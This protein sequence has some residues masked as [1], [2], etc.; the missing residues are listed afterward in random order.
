MARKNSTAALYKRADSPQ[1]KDERRQMILQAATA[2]LAQLDSLDD[3]TMEALSKRAGLAKGTVYLYFKNKNSLFFVM[4]EDAV[5][6]L[7]LD[8]HARIST[9][10]KPVEAQKVAYAIRDELMR[11]VKVNRLPWLFKSLSG[12]GNALGLPCA[13]EKFESK[14]RPFTDRVDD[15]LVKSLKGLRPENGDQIMIYAWSLLLGLSEVIESDPKHS[16][17]KSKRRVVESVEQGLGD[18]L[19]LIIEGLQNRS[20]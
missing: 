9:L 6:S 17:S 8:I 3:F 15:I 4:L 12:E 11:S 1:Q 7:M 2:E 18:A 5:Q 20:R 14:I 10:G 16:R 19:T 13:R